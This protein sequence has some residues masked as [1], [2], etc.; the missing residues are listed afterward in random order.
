MCR[1]LFVLLTF[2]VVL[3]LAGANVAFGDVIEVRIADEFDDTEEDIDP[4][5]LGEGDADSSDLEMPYEDTGMGD[6]QLIGLRYQVDIPQGA[7]I[8]EAWVRFQVDELKDGSLPVNLIIEGELNPNPGQFV[9]GGA[10]TFDVSTRS[11]TAAQVQWSAANWE[12][13]GDQGPAQTTTNIAS[14]IQ[15]IVNQA[16]WASGN[17]LV[18]II[19]DDPAN[20]SEGNRVA[21]AGP[22]DDSAL[23]HVDFTVGGGL[24]PGIAISTQ[25]GWFGQGAADR[26]MQEIVDNVTA[27][28]V[29]QFAADQQD[30]LADWVIAHTGDGVSDLLILCGNFPD[31]IYPPGNAEPD[32]SLA[33]LFLDDGNTIVN[34]GD[35][36]FY[37][38]SGGTNNNA[39]GGL[40]NMMD[41][42]NGAIDMWDDN[43]P[44]NVT[45][46]GA[47]VAPSL[48]DFQTDR[49]FHLDAL[50]GDWVPE[51]ILA[52]NDAGTRA[53]PVIVVNTVTGGR[54]GIFYQ[55]AGQDDDPRGEVMS[56]WI[57]NYVLTGGEI[58][59]GPAGSPNPADGDID[60][61]ATALEWAAGYGA[62]L[63]RVY[64]S[65]DATIDDADLLGETD[66]TLQVAV[67]DPGVTYNWRVDEVD[68]DG[69]VTEGPVWSFSTLPLEA[70]FPVPAD[71]AT[72][73]I[74][75]E[76]SWTAGKDTIMHNVNYGT[77]PAVL[78]PVSM[79]QMGTTYDPGALDPDMT[80]YWRVDEFTPA[81]TVT[82]PV[83]SFSTLGAVTPSGLP[84]LIAQF[85]FDED[86]GTLSALDTSGNDHHGPLLGDASIAGGVL[87]VDG[88]GDAV[89]AGGDPAFHPA[90]AFSISA[91][92]N[93]SGWGGDWGNAIAGTRG[94]SGLGWQLRRH[95]G[96]QNLTFTVR[97]TPGA[98]DPQGTIVPP[99]NEWIHVAAVFDPDGGTR[100]VYI[101]GI[102]DVQIEDSGAVSVSDHNLF[103]GA[104]ASGGNTPEA[105]FNGDIDY[106]HIYN[107]ALTVDE[108]RL[109]GADLTLPWSPDPANG[110]SGLSSSGVTLSWNAG[111]GA[112]E[113]DV[114]F[115]LDAA[116]VAAADASDATGIYRGR[117][118]ETT[119]VPADLTSDATHYWR[120][121]QVDGDGNVVAGPVWS[122]GVALLVPASANLG[123][124]TSDVSGFQIYS[125]KPQDSAGWG[126]N[127]LIEILDTGLLNGVGAVEE[128][129]RIDEFVNLRDTG[130]GAFGDDKSF[131]GIDALEVP[132]QDPADGDDDNDFGTE[133]LGSIHLTAGMHQIGAN[134]DDGTIVWIGG[135]EIGRTGEWKGASN[136]DLPAFEVEV[137]GYYDLRAITMEGGGGASV[138][139]HE[140]LAD[141]TR[142]LLNDVA[143]GGSAVFAAALAEGPVNIMFNGGL[144][145]DVSGAGWSTYGD[146]AM[147]V[148]QELVGAAVPEAPI[149]GSSCLHVTVNSAGANFWDAGLQHGGHVFE[150]GKSYTLSASLKAKEGTMNINFKPELAA[151]PWSGYGSQEFTMTD[152]W[153]E[154]TVNTGVMEANVDPASITFHIAYAPG[155][156]WVDDVKF[157]ED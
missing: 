118:A 67:L 79:M 59:N 76:L 143:N 8:N 147:E 81:G 132:A 84:D 125:F 16:G 103:I 134:S 126:Y 60:S 83:W 82:G 157:Y 18:L 22:G 53:D 96:N 56:E 117:Q 119:Y 12:N 129:T 100:S 68:A 24:N 31:T 149:E 107:R 144:E 108:I 15:E 64:L 85:E 145:D 52:Q 42:A 98:D 93:M 34:T 58:P 150:A 32:G 139:L 35:Y 10:G 142:L 156:F 51:L 151:D 109:V 41:I 3:G 115:G 6:P 36:M 102:L 2:F 26:E 20:P 14:V 17:A 9:E 39:A 101:N 97:G 135:I 28:P 90:G 77:D 4:G 127:G 99:L 25:A 45:A 106:V 154:Y 33:E 7:T 133:I 128:G 65:T 124:A 137:D 80:Y 75:V 141:G 62:V 1:K 122:F 69:N 23:L 71:G 86:A 43:T 72:N 63:H 74:S 136:V 70:H 105:F 61:D 94:E 55:T 5:K 73:A 88:N 48:Q 140:I 153:A 37:V 47:A 46:E 148:V 116:A 54:L 112:V 155:E 95:S 38:N 19:T 152:T 27:V 11:R 138:E 40:Q 130:N 120:V 50:E 131:P 29:E 57:N 110:A 87:S 104:R 91:F 146:A 123:A 121:D 92:V 44:A 89:D 30:A 78:L 111:D 49:P 113:Q 66:L 114:Y 13:V 21:E